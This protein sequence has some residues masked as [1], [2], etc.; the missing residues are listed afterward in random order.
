M[1]PTY[2]ALRS[3]LQP[4]ISCQQTC[5]KRGMVRQQRDWTLPMRSPQ[6]QGKCCP[7]SLYAK[8]LME[9]FVPG[10]SSAPSILVPGHVIM[11]VPGPSKYACR[12]SVNNQH[13]RLM[14]H[15]P[16]HK[17]LVVKPGL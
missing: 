6:K 2:N 4:G 15:L 14:F 5:R 7:G 3:T 13:R 12:E 8:P 11:P 16:H 9:R 1:M 10:C 17:L